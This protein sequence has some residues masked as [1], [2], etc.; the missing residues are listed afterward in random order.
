M[1]DVTIT[2]S[3]IVNSSDLRAEGIV[4]QDDK[5]EESFSLELHHIQLIASNNSIT[6]EE[7]QQSPYTIDERTGGDNSSI[8]AQTADEASN[9]TVNDIL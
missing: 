6:K 8:V 3:D 1:E 2:N 5:V 9:V 4:G 7:Q